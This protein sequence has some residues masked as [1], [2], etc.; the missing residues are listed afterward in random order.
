MSDPR[1]SFTERKSFNIRGNDE[2]SNPNSMS[3]PESVD[4]IISLGSKLDIPSRSGELDSPDMLSEQTAL[5]GVS[6]RWRI[7]RFVT[8]DHDFYKLLF[9]NFEGESFKISTIQV[10]LGF[11]RF[12]KLIRRDFTKHLAKAL[13]EL[14]SEDKQI[15]W[16][17][18]LE[19][20]H[21]S[22]A[23]SRFRGLNKLRASQETDFSF[24]RVT[25]IALT[26]AER[27]F[28]TVE[29]GG[30]SALA[31][32]YSGIRLIV[33]ALS[34]TFIVLESCPSLK[35]SSRECGHQDPICTG[36]PEAP[37]YFLNVEIATVA[38]FTFDYLVRV[39]LAGF[40]RHELMDKPMLIDMSVGRRRLAKSKKFAKRL[41]L[42]LTKFIC[43]V[44]LA[45]I[46]PFYVQL[47][48]GRQSQSMQVFRVI[49]LIS[50]LRLLRLRDVRDIQL[51]IYR[52]F[53]AA[54]MT[55]VLLFSVFLVM[56]LFFAVVM[57]YAES[58]EWYPAGSLID[59]VSISQGN[60]YRLDLLGNLQVT[61]F[62]SVPAA[63]YWAIIT[64]TTV[65]YGD[66]TPTSEWGRLVAS[67]LS[68][69]GIIVLAMPIAVIGS[70]FSQEHD[71]YFSI[72]HCLRLSKEQEVQKR[73]MNKLMNDWHLHS[74]QS[75]LELIRNPSDHAVSDKL[76]NQL[77]SDLNAGA[78][79]STGAPQIHMHLTA[80]L[81]HGPE[82]VKPQDLNQFLLSSF[83]LLDQ[84]KASMSEEKYENL[85]QLLLDIAMTVTRCIKP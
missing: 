51:I 7:P 83:D 71:R 45:S 32:I 41:I 81:A 34:V 75:Q 58:G 3:S 78:I 53:R 46:L 60:Y 85:R 39:G 62:S 61:P 48:V 52:A 63:V 42:Y 10:L 23:K 13:V 70:N 28:L 5:H 69:L 12:L 29:D 80:L 15:G 33:I 59:G 16:D 64:A 54:A 18:Y 36:E 73:L 26:G 74:R 79:A 50:V 77:A 65:G 19:L 76:I 55:L 9:L 25:C 35:S 8:L 49:R 11:Q 4:G 43:L 38:V 20:M 2:P 27:A 47:A 21:S 40:V 84:T 6:L 44:D 67:I 72:K 66:I 14:Q 37:Y 68:I 1:L 22:E 57:Y 82:T 24:D 17:K 56:I 31:A 30:T